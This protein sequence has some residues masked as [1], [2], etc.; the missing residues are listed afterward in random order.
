[1]Y[2]YSKTGNYWKIKTGF[3]TFNIIKH[4][5][6]V[7]PFMVDPDEACGARS[8]VVFDWPLSSSEKHLRLVNVS[9]L[10]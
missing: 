7:T 10:S 3:E 5:E 1:M 6:P 9:C 2:M 4:L 8:T